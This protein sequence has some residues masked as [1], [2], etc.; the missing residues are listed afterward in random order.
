MAKAA[1]CWQ[2]KKPVLTQHTIFRR[3]S[4]LQGFKDA[5][6]SNSDPTSDIRNPLPAFLPAIAF[7]A[8]KPVSSLGSPQSGLLQYVPPLIPKGSPPSPMSGQD[9]EVFYPFL[10]QEFNVNTCP[11]SWSLFL[12]RRKACRQGRGLTAEEPSLRHDE[13]AEVLSTFPDHFLP[14]LLE[15][16]LL[17]S[18]RTILKFIGYYGLLMSY[19]CGHCDQFPISS[20]VLLFCKQSWMSFGSCPKLSSIFGWRIITYSS[21]I[22]L[23]K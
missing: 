7:T 12:R 2:E 3:V 23:I 19:V 1:I 14:L 10:Q 16:V 4:H 11:I 13:V 6:L 20:V 17:K 21:T 18:T 5:S 9:H 8:Q 15:K 22:Y